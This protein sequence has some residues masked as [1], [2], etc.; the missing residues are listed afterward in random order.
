VLRAHKKGY[1]IIELPVKERDRD[2]GKSSV[3]FAV[4]YK[5]IRDIFSYRFGDKGRLLNKQNKK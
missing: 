5:M 1:R 3:N 4:A 2:G